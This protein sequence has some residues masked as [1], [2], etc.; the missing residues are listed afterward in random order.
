M[1]L[2]D[3]FNTVVV[4]ALLSVTQA[5]WCNFYY[6]DTCTNDANGGVSFDCSN[7]GIIASGGGFV[8]CHSTFR[9]ND[10][11]EVFRCN[12]DECSEGG[13]AWKVQPDQSCINMEGAGPY[14]QLYLL[15]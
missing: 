10:M 4:A 3:L 6:D 2:F 1:K 14:Y 13:K 7:H 9:N 5:S 12:N 8:K 15:I 11:C